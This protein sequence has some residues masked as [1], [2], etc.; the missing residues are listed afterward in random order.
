M[1]DLFE[2]DF[3]TFLNTRKPAAPQFVGTPSLIEQVVSDASFDIVDIKS[4]SLPITREVG[5]GNATY[6]NS[7]NK[8]LHF[9]DYENIINQMDDILVRDL[10][11]C[12]YIVYEEGGN[13]CFILNELSEG[14]NPANKRSKARSQLS[15]TLLV[16]KQIPSIWSR[17]ETCSQKQCIFSNRESSVVIPM[18]MASP[19]LEINN[20]LPDPIPLNAGQITNNGFEALET[21]KIEIR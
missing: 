20:L 19:F 17:I 12:D 4:T 5:L 13:S 11:R 7:S 21:S 1:R 10:K 2:N 3:I 14:S 8:N 15:G 9:I 6:I 18:N 16:L